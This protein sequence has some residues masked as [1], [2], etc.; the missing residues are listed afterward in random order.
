MLAQAI[1]MGVGL[2]G[3]VFG[4]VLGESS[5]QK[6]LEEQE[7]ELEQGYEK[8]IDKL[9]QMYPMLYSNFRAARHWLKKAFQLYK[10]YRQMGERVL[11]GL[12]AKLEPGGAL[13]D[14][15]LKEGERT[16]AQRMSS[17]GLY[18]SGARL[19][20]GRRNVNQLTGE[21][22]DKSFGR[23]L[24]ALMLALRGVQGEAGIKS[25][26]GGMRYDV[27]KSMIPAW[28][29]SAEYLTDIGKIGTGAQ[30]GA[31]RGNLYQSLG[32]LPSQIFSMY[33]AYNQPQ[34]KT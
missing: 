5:A 25:E 30:Q 33:N 12:E 31:M 11:P 6:G 7:A 10:P 19:E 18:D 22:T 32:S 23:T 9:M 3:N 4:N 2:A 28:M 21:E 1:G 17:M 8:A 15:R 27:G 34:P 29:Q 16:D 14:W 20:L 13:Y 24:Q 26:I